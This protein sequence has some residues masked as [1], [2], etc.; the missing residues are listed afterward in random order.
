M[1][2]DKVLDGETA[3][4]GRFPYM[5]TLRDPQDPDWVF[6]AGTLIH[7][8]LVL[9]AAHCL[10]DAS[11]EDPLIVICGDYEPALHNGTDIR[12]AKDFA[13]HPN[14]NVPKRKANDAGLILLDAPAVNTPVVQL[15]TPEQ[16]SA[17]VEAKPV[18]W[19]AGW[20]RT[21]MEEAEGQTKTVPVHAEVLQQ[22]RTPL[23]DTTK[24][25]LG[26]Q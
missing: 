26:A 17:I 6:C 11:Q 3:P 16:W 14:Y 9:T 10:S 5:C 8:Q 22:F 7:P 2:V 24:V 15:A 1:Q 20:G 25:T 21:Y 4:E 13:Q 23:L 19:G 18:L 12:R